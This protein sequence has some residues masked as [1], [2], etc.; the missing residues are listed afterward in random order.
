MDDGD[1]GFLGGFN[2]EKYMKMM[3]VLK[4]IVI[5][6]FLFLCVNGLLWIIGVGKVMCYWIDVLGWM[7]G[8]GFGMDDF[9]VNVLLL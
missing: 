9:V 3:G 4:V 2:V 7:Y 8:F 5:C 1:G 6:D